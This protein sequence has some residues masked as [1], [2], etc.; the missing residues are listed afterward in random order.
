[1]HR[2][3]SLSGDA[4]N[5][6]PVGDTDR[7]SRPGVAL[8]TAWIAQ[9]SRHHHID[10]ALLATRS[11]VLAFV[12]GEDGSRLSSGWRHDLVGAPVQQLVSGGAAL[13]FDEVT[14]DL[15]LEERSRNAIELALPTARPRQ[16]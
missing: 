1:V 12:R 10:A 15:V 13:A 11:D 16:R 9:L 7:E 2:G 6:P 5:V 3:A 14:G 8:A 4:I